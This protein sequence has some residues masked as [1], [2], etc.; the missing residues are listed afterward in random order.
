MHSR[1]LTTRC[2]PAGAQ[3]AR[4]DLGIRG[5]D[6]GCGC[7]CRGRFVVGIPVRH[8]RRC[9]DQLLA[10]CPQ[11]FGL[12]LHLH[13]LGHL[14]RRTPHRL[15]C[16]HGQPGAGIVAAAF[17]LAGGTTAGGHRRRGLSVLVTGQPVDW[18]LLHGQ[19]ETGRSQRHLTDRNLRRC[20][21]RHGND[22]RIVESEGRHYLWRATG[23]VSRQRRRRHAAIVRDGEWHRR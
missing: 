2:R 13:R 22:W 23:H 17:E 10:G 21:R 18:V 16:R 12:Q 9:G 11:R 19:T 8:R 5:C 20:R 1:S 4:V 7:D 15:P 14:S 6:R 3:A